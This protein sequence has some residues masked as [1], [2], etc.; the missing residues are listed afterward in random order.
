MKLHLT[1]VGLQI[2]L[3]KASEIGLYVTEGRQV[4]LVHKFAIIHKACIH[5]TKKV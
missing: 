1:K 5:L 4:Q 3:E 2:L